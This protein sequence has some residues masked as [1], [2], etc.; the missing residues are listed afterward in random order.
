[1]AVKLTKC[2]KIYQHLP[3]AGPSNIYSNS[4]FW[5]ENIPS[6]NP[7]ANTPHPQPHAPVLELEKLVVDVLDVDLGPRDVVVVVDAV[8]DVVV[9][10]V[11]TLEQVQLLE[12]IL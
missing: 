5:F 10:F 3:F 12:S 9:Q 1:M 11:E 6:G 2:H 4:H 7:A 8:D